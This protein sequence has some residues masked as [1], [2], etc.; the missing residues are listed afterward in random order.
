MIL[1]HI[2][3]TFFILFCP[4]QPN[5]Q[6]L[7]SIGYKLVPLAQELLDL[8]TGHHRQEFIIR[9]TRKSSLILPC[10]PSTCFVPHTCLRFFNLKRLIDVPAH[11]FHPHNQSQSHFISMDSL[12]DSPDFTICL[13]LLALFLPILLLAIC[14]FL[15]V[16]GIT[17]LQWD[18]F[19]VWTFCRCSS[20]HSSQGDISLTTFTIISTP[21]C[22]SSILMPLPIASVPTP[23]SS[24]EDFSIIP[25]GLYIPPEPQTPPP[26]PPAIK[27][28][29]DM[30]FNANVIDLYYHYSE[31]AFTSTLDLISQDPF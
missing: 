24:T 18:L 21:V 15:Y 30:W 5:L 12:S 14:S 19:Y 8:Y 23:P 25:P 4:H 11:P 3:S 7:L 31:F 26:T 29:D 2:S 6:G 16:Q 1:F 20:P 22:G 27:I 10:M 17:Q 9:L 13:I 28:A